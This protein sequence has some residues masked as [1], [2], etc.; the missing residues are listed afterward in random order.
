MEFATLAAGAVAVWRYRLPFLVLPIAV[1][2][3]YMSMDLVPLLLGGEAKDFFSDKGKLVSTGFGLWMMFVAFWV[4]VRSR[5]PKDFAFWLYMFGVLA[6]WGG[7][8]SM[9]SNSELGKFVYCCINLLLIAVGAAL[10]RRVFAVFGAVGVALYLG[11]LSHSVFKDSMLFPIA[12][13]AIGLA[14]I[15]A[16]VFWQRREAAIGAW[17]RSHLPTALREL[18]ERRAAH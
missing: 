17:L 2:L 5:N 14:V 7:L 6:F 18:V 9:N 10:A 8:T 12:L 16:G 1:T 13:T 3:W 4:D 11:H 15:C